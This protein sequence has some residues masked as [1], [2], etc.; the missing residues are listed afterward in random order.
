MP[1]CFACQGT[2]FNLLDGLYFCNDCGTQC[3]DIQQE[4]EHAYHE[5]EGTMRRSQIQRIHMPQVQKEQLAETARMEKRRE[6]EEAKSQKRVDKRKRIYLRDAAEWERA[7]NTWQ[8]PKRKKLEPRIYKQ[9]SHAEVYQSLLKAQVR[10]LINMGFS[11]DLKG[12]VGQ[13]WF[14]LL[15]SCQE[16][17]IDN[18]DEEVVLEKSVENGTNGLQFDPEDEG[19]EPSDKPT[20]SMFRFFLQNPK[21]GKI[22]VGYQGKVNVLLGL[23]YLGILCLGE[24]VLER[25]LSRWIQQG[26]FPYL[27]FLD[28]FPKDFNAKAAGYVAAATNPKVPSEKTILSTVKALICTI[29]LS[30]EY[31][32]MIDSHSVCQ[33]FA[34]EL[35]LPD[36][37]RC[38]LSGLLRVHSPDCRQ[39][40]FEKGSSFPSLATLPCMAVVVIAMKICY[41]LDDDNEFS[42][43]GKALDETVSWLGWLRRLARDWAEKHRIKRTADFFKLADD[44]TLYSTV[45]DLTI[46]SKAKDPNPFSEFHDADVDN[47]GVIGPWQNSASEVTH[48]GKTPDQETAAAYILCFSQRK[49]LPLETNSVHLL[50]AI[51]SLYLGCR[52]EDMYQC[53]IMQE[54]FYLH[55][56]QQEG[57]KP[58][59]IQKLQ[60]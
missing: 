28:Y 60:A 47:V 24:V 55:H 3:E 11:S 32:P 56:S 19:G 16:A 8:R 26:H 27:N 22:G 30:R 44:P 43:E 51:C 15:R 21:L 1:R 29:A 45:W 33:R 7:K 4:E 40:L 6:K 36:F 23:C 57:K 58:G 35:L 12:V 2:S 50:I 41:H 14:S 20:P 31:I 13:L 42:S 34:E 48:A 38:T 49:A 25:D 52:P 53:T 37:A 46:L 18:F 39:Y 59:K 54:K 17:F 9:Y 10:A 5:E